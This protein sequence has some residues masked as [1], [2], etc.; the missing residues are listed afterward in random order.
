M[1]KK[2]LQVIK[3]VSGKTKLYNS[4]LPR[5]IIIN[6]HDI[7]NNKVIAESF[8]NVGPN[9][10]SKIPKTSND[11]SKYL[12][13]TDSIMSQYNLIDKELEEASL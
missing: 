7:Y 1:L 8:I 10:A 5:R 4:F 13:H 12:K 2:T 11:I 9:L 6:N 3:E